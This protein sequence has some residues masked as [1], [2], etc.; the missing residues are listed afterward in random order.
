MDNFTLMSWK[1]F[2]VVGSTLS[3]V[4]IITPSGKMEEKELVTIVSPRLIFTCFAISVN[5]PC[6]ASDPSQTMEPVKAYATALMG[7]TYPS[8]KR[9]ME[10]YGSAY[11][12]G[13]GKTGYFELRGLSTIDI[14]R[15]DD[16]KLAESIIKALRE[17]R[18]LPIR[19]YGEN[20]T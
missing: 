4:P 10:K 15:E 14:D 12:G 11:H 19:Y 1:L 2:P 5:A 20:T 6:V 18:E 17:N 7:W 3:T 16:F 8:F 13:D 9:N